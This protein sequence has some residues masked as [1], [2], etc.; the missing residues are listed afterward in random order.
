LGA[1]A[2]GAAASPRRRRRSR[3]PLGDPLELLDLVLLELAVVALA[4]PLERQR[5]DARAREALD[6]VAHGREH[7]AHLAV[8][9]FADRDPELGLVRL[10][11]HDPHARRQRLA[12]G[13]PDA[14]AQLADRGVVDR[15]A[16]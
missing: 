6:L 2:R 8:L 11:L 10:A 9:A 3:V 7:A 14:C 4:Q 13:E 12:F 15:A 5:P 1:L 16:D